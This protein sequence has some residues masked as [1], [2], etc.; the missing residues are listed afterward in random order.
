M[1]TK[2]YPVNIIVSTSQSKTILVPQ[3]LRPAC[4]PSGKKFQFLQKLTCIRFYTLKSFLLILYFMIYCILFVLHYDFFCR[5]WDLSP[6]CSQ[7]FLLIYDI[8]YLTAIGLTPGG[9]ST[10]HIYPNNI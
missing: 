10:V 1:Q 3:R 8:M 7:K 5:G 6:D 4:V 9:S 2:F